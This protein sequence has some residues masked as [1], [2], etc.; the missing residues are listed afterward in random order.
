MALGTFLAGQLISNPKGMISN[1]IGTITKDAVENPFSTAGSLA[2][3]LMT[4]GF[5]I[6]ATG[7]GRGI[8]SYN[9]SVQADKDLQAM[10][11]HATGPSG[12]DRTTSAWRD[13]FGKDAEEQKK[14]IVD[15]VKRKITFAGLPLVGD[16]EE[17]NW[18]SDLDFDT[19]LPPPI[20]E[21]SQTELP[22]LDVTVP[23][24]TNTSSGAFYNSGTK[25]NVIYK[26][27]TSI[28]IDPNAPDDPRDDPLGSYLGVENMTPEQYINSPQQARDIAVAQ[29]YADSQMGQGGY[30]ADGPGGDDWASWD[31]DYGGW[32]Y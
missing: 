17:E 22:S 29:Q 30:D 25:G 32:D 14:D 26:N 28:S 19:T 16:K 18:T 10:G 5:G 7:I 15:E 23:S 27:P 4:P 13:F 24:A 1:P 21:V 9:Q 6:I 12:E 8:D 2:G 11:I 3:S 20:A 31:E